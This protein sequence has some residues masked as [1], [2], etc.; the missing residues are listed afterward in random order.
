MPRK[1]KREKR[2]KI[3]VGI[4]VSFLMVSS[5]AGFV[6]LNS[7]NNQEVNKFTLTYS[8]KDYEFTRKQD[9][10]GNQ[11]YEVS[12]DKGI[13]TTYYHPQQLNNIEISQEVISVIKNTNFF[14]LTFD[15][16]QSDLSY[17]DYLRFDLK[18]NIPQA[19]YFEEGITRESDVYNLPLITCQNATPYVPVIFLKNSTMTNITMIDNCINLEFPTYEILKI[20]DMLVYLLQGIDIE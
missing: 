4:I 6:I 15:P 2:N 3:I 8:N 5:I 20:R 19:I 11:Y 9:N 18:N 12:S 13:F 1:D 17:V 16:Q 7:T 14:Y 10:L